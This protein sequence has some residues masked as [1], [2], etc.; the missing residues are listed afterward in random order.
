MQLTDELPSDDGVRLDWL[1]LAGSR[2]LVVGAGGIGAECAKGYVAAG[3]QVVVVD[4]DQ[5]RLDALEAA[6]SFDAPTSPSRALA[7]TR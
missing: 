4:R 3:A 5:V 1:G 7:R 2:V 6:P